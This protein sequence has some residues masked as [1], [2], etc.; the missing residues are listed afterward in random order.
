MVPAITC[1]QLLAVIVSSRTIDRDGRH[2]SDPDH[3]PQAIQP[4]SVGWL[5]DADPTPWGSAYKGDIA[6]RHANPIVFPPRPC[7]EVLR[8]A[9]RNATAF[10]T[11]PYDCRHRIHRLPTNRITR[12]S[13]FRSWNLRRIQSLGARTRSLENDHVAARVTR[14]VPL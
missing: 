13:P 12:T 1:T 2:H 7:L 4:D 3:P 9:A 14:Q 8:P 5:L 10:Y 6:H 11:S